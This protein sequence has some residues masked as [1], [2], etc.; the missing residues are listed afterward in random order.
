MVL[1]LGTCLGLWGV[2][3]V[4]WDELGWVWLEHLQ[5][6]E[7]T[8]EGSC[9]IWENMNIPVHKNRATSR[10]SGQRRDVPES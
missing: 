6:V 1:D 9:C 5:K 3:K 10:R 8:G 2:S 4:G 7:Q